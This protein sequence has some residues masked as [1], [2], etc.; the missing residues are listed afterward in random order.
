MDIQSLAKDR[1][2][3]VS[4]VITIKVQGPRSRNPFL[5]QPGGAVEVFR[6]RFVIGIEFDIR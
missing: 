1:F 5:D 3:S 4:I 2:L 6:I